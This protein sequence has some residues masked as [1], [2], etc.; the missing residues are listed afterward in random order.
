[1]SVFLTM[2]CA[3]EL[4]LGSTSNIGER[5]QFENVMGSQMLEL[6]ILRLQIFRYLSVSKSETA[7]INFD[8]Q[9]FS[10]KCVQDRRLGVKTEGSPTGNPSPAPGTRTARTARTT[11]QINGA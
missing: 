9:R 11:R 2:W 4:L 6:V 3:T 8:L 5:T 1:M 7:C 10:E